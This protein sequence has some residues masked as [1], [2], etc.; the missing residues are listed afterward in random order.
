MRM[1]NIGIAVVL[2]LGLLGGAVSAVAQTDPR[3]QIVT[4]VN[5]QNAP[6]REAL[7]I[8]LKDANYTISN[9]VEGKV[10][11][12]LSN[13]PLETA[14]RNL[15]S[16]IDATYSVDS[17]YTFKIVPAPKEDLGMEGLPPKV[18][19]PEPQKHLIRRIRIRHADPQ[20]IY[21]LL[22]GRATFTTPPEISVLQRSSGV[23]GPGGGFGDGPASGLDGNGGFGLSGIFPG[24]GHASGPDYGGFSGTGGAFSNRG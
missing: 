23:L 14:L 2:A 15:L 21:L 13:V 20:Y 9:L 12:S 24:S 11:A 22:L 5:F 19:G 4:S 1:K 6:I 17:H 3:G 10:T 18:L 7:R 16:Q 8:L